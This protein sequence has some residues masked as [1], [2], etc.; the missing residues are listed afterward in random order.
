MTMNL[1]ALLLT[2]G[3]VISGVL[4]ISTALRSGRRYTAPGAPVQDDHEAAFLNGGPAR[5]V[6]T[7]LTALHTDG[8]VMIGGPGIVSVVRA[9]PRDPVERAVLHELA[10]APNGALHILRLAVM[11]H[12]AVQEIGDGLAARGLL[13]RPEEQRTRRR[14]GGIQGGISLVLF[15]VSIIATIAQYSA[16]DGQTEMPFPFVLKMLPAILFGAV[17]GL[18]VSA[19]ARARITKAGRAAAASYRRAH[20]TGGTPAQQVAAS[21]LRTLTDTALRDQ[22][23]A[24]ARYGAPRPPRRGGYSPPRRGGAGA[25]SGAGVAMVPVV[26]CASAGP[27]GG[28]GSSC[29]AGGGS[30]CGGSGFG[31]GGSGSSCGGGG[32]SC[33]GGG[34]S[35]GGS[36]SSCGGGSSS[37][38]GGG[39]SSCGGGSS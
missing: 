2:L 16:F 37:S 28:S 11:H 22:L 26:W 34:S 5:V 24:A 1:L 38:C 35:C 29:G 20:A 27:G 25:T 7:A 12:P 4:L 31:C 6:D 10:L 23:T 17:S 36:S 19:R 14:W 21:G 8:R 33:G 13:A 3:I 30:S 18:V 15:P 32:S 9:Q 39:G